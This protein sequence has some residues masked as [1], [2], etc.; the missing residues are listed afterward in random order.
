MHNVDWNGAAVF[1]GAFGAFCGSMLTVFMQYM[2]W[3]DTRREKQNAARR[4]RTLNKVAQTVG[5]TPED[6]DGKTS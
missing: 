1:L 2:N 5:V 4:E 3:R 6:H